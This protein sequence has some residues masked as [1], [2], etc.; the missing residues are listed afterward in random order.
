VHLG[1]ATVIPGA[2]TKVHESN[3]MA[4]NLDKSLTPEI[5]IFVPQLQ[6]STNKSFIAISTGTLR[7][8]RYMFLGK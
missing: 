8:R 2:F 4:R 6:T 1:I 7:Q 3:S 5:L